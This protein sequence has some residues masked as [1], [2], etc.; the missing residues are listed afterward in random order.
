MKRE[1]TVQSNNYSAHAGCPY[2]CGFNASAMVPRQGYGDLTASVRS[3]RRGVRHAMQ[4][5]IDNNHKDEE[6]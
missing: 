3:T 1:F 2:R 6:K 5:H 4:K